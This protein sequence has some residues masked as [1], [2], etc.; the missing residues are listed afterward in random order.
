MT[1]TRRV[2]AFFLTFALVGALAACGGDD[3]GGTTETGADRDRSAQGGVPV[4]RVDDVDGDDSGNDVGESGSNG[5]SG[6]G[7]GPGI[8][9]LSDLERCLE[10]SGLLGGLAF[11]PMMI[12]GGGDPEELAELREQISA[13]EALL[14]NDLRDDYQLVQDA[15]TEFF[16]ALLELDLENNP[17]ALFDPATA[18]IMEEASAG[19]DDA[20][21][22]AALERI[23]QYID[24]ECS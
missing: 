6:S 1:S 20:E 2:L 21:V 24:A 17:A 9:S 3:G 12:A 16:E 15:Y 4:E 18:Q 14:P 5:G 8:G 11:V 7:S 10:L 19:I 22:Q 13:S 23:T